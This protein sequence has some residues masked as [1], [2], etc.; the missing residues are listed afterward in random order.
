MSSN[1]GVRPYQD[2]DIPRQTCSI[3]CS[4]GY[5]YYACSV[6]GLCSCCHNETNM[7]IV[8]IKDNGKYLCHQCDDRIKVETDK[9]T[10]DL[11]N[12]ID[13]KSMF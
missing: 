1:S 11:L 2:G 12:S 3:L 5:A 6:K 13:F 8:N 10:R 7:W 9:Q 4:P